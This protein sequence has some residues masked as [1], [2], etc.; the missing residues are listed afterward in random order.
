MKPALS[1]QKPDLRAA[2]GLVGDIGRITISGDER[3]VRATQS[4]VGALRERLRGGE[5]V[6]NTPAAYLHSVDSPVFL[7]G[8]MWALSDVLDRRLEAI[9]EQRAHG[10]RNTRK[11]QVTN[12]ISDALMRDE[13]VSPS[14]LLSSTLEDGTTVR[15][16]SISRLQ[17][18]ERQ[19]LS[20]CRFRRSGPKEVLCADTGRKGCD[21]RPRVPRLRVV[22]A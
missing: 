11:E 5:H 20:S 6:K 21:E 16:D 2:L 1:A 17:R 14:D 3:D 15:R 10:R 12:L 13:A 19:R 8:A 4:A 9:G 7:A 18:L 22:G